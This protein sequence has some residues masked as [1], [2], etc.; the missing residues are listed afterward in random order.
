MTAT[1]IKLE[2]FGEVPVGGGSDARTEEE[3][4]RAYQQGFQA[5]ETHARNQALTALLVEITAMSRQLHENEEELRK[6]HDETLRGVLPLFDAIL[7]MA[8]PIALR[9]RLR[10]ALLAELHRLSRNRSPLRCTIHCN[11]AIAADVQRIIAELDATNIEIGT[12]EQDISRIRILV[13]GGTILINPAAATANARRLI[14][15]IIGEVGKD[16]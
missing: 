3:A 5:G 12:A 6:A 4:R 11:P 15:F 9:E 1:A 13:D 8:A 7:D 2:R 16:D 10:D 14:G